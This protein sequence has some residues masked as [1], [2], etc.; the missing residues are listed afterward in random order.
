MQCSLLILL[1]NGPME[2]SA[3]GTVI[4]TRYIEAT[5]LFK[6]KEAPFTQI[7]FLGLNLLL[8]EEVH[9]VNKKFVVIASGNATLMALI[10]LL[11]QVSYFLDLE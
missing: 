5:L 8:R 3:T 10:T 2:K 7:I 9:K 1:R 11:Y 6:N 4:K